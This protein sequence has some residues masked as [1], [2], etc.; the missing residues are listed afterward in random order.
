MDNNHLDGIFPKKLPNFLER[1][2]IINFY[3]IILF[4]LYKNLKRTMS[5][6]NITGHLPNKLPKN[7][8]KLFVYYF[9]YKQNI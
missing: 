3:R 7:L 6:N 8:K 1:M 5:N 4:Y 2:Y 9:F